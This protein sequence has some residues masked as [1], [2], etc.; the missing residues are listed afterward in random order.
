VLV[1]SASPETST[2]FDGS[3]TEMCPSVCPGVSM[4]CRPNTS[5]PCFT[6]LSFVL[7]MIASTSRMAA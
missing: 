2:P 1:R 6:G 4:I 3:N 7:V 5:S